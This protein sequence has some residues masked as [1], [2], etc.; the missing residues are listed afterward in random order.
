VI[1]SLKLF[2]SPILIALVSLVG[3]RWGPAVSG[4]FLGFPLTSA[5][6]SI[7]LALQY[8]NVFAANSASGNLGGQASVCIFCLAFSFAA[9]R[10]NWL[11]SS[12]IAIGFFLLSALFL[13]LFTLTLVSAFLILLATVAVALRI[14]PKAKDIPAIA[15]I[16]QWDLPVRMILAALFV[17]FVTA[18]AAGLGPQ[19]SGLIAPFPVFGV[20]MAA[21]A[22]KQG[23]INAALKLFH[24]YLTASAGYAFFFL[25]VGLLLPSQGILITYILAMIV[26]FIVNGIS[27]LK[28]TRSTV[29]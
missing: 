13:N 23:G 28:S 4:W 2:L 1:L 8:G 21:F 10:F 19:L 11:V 26:I 29:L 15:V 12:C 27:F 24:G 3:R 16:P 17:I 7:L 20:I 6:I 14:M 18:V 5:P 9:H 22:F 25:V